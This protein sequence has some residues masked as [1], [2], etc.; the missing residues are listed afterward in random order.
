MAA[1]EHAER[2]AYLCE[3]FGLRVVHYTDVEI[4]ALI[5]A[6]KEAA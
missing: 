2:D 3:R 6:R 5:R 1:P 4:R